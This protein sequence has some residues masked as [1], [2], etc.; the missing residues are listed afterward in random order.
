MTP[1]GLR[2]SIA[3]QPFRLTRY[4]YPIV[5][6]TVIVELHEFPL[7]PWCIGARRT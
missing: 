5:V 7:R 3:R 6:A 4:S 1:A 2:L